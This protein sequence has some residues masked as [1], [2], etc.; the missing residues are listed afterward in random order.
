VDSE[1]SDDYFEELN[2]QV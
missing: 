1:D 2:K